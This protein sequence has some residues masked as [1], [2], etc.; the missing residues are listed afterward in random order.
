MAL[1]TDD[2]HLALLDNF[3]TTDLWG[4]LWLMEPKASAS[5]AILATR[6]LSRTPARFAGVKPGNLVAAT[7][8]IGAGETAR[9]PNTVNP[10]AVRTRFE[11]RPT[12]GR[13]I[14]LSPQIRPLLRSFGVVPGPSQGIRKCRNEVRSTP[15]DSPGRRGPRGSVLRRKG[16]RP[17]PVSRLR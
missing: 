3:P 11:P 1:R 17:R 9:I 14:E 2:E 15:C 16:P 6:G 5:G 12:A 13:A 10:I 7:V 4:S 8:A